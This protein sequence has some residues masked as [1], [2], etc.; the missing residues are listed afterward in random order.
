MQTAELR[1]ESWQ[2]EYKP[3]RPWQNEYNRGTL[4]LRASDCYPF[5]LC[6]LP[7][8]CFDPSRADPQLPQDLVVLFV[9]CFPPCF[10]FSPSHY[11]RHVCPHIPCIPRCLLFRTKFCLHP[12]P[13]LHHPRLLTV[14]PVVTLVTGFAFCVQQP[15]RQRGTPA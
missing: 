15:N 8:P 11:L 2:N 10:Y 3:W 9:C 1:V 4:E 12:F 7:S 14:R 5:L 6:F 13:A